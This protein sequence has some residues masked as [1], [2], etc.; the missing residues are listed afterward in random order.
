MVAIFTVHLLHLSGHPAE[1]AK[2]LYRKIVYLA[3]ILT[4]DS[5]MHLQDGRAQSLM[6]GCMKMPMIC[7]SQLASITL[8][9]LVFHTPTISLF[10]IEVYAI[11]LLNGIMQVSG[12]LPFSIMFYAIKK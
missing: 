2:D 7:T 8:L 10:L 11:T 5:F 3:A 4:S 9:M 12:K 6:H 1:I